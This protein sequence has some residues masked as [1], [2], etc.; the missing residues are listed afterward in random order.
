[1]NLSD[2]GIFPYRYGFSARY[3]IQGVHGNFHLGNTDFINDEVHQFFKSRGGIMK[4]MNP[5][6]KS[7]N[8]AQVFSIY[9]C[10]EV[11]CGQGHDR[12]EHPFEKWGTDYYHPQF[13]VLETK[14]ATFILYYRK[15]E[16]FLF[17]DEKICFDQQKWQCH[18]PL[19]DMYELL[20]MKMKDVSMVFSFNC[21]AGNI[22]HQ[23][24]EGI[25]RNKMK[26][27]LADGP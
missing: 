20:D 14:K 21:T 23:V 27:L 8:T 17:L 12:F 18:E 1:M 22:F 9:G 25:L 6:E 24:T 5:Q 7:S 11:L 13:D 19:D 2:F 16:A 15:K 10:R 4:V 26:G 3:F